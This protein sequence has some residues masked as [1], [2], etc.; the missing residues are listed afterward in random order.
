MKLTDKQLIMHGRTAFYSWIRAEKIAARAVEELPDQ[1]DQLFNR[2]MLAYI[3][4]FTAGWKTF[5]GNQERVK[6]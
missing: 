2:V 4:G 1:K 6:D 5:K 3:T